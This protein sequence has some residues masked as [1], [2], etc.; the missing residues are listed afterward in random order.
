VVAD[1]VEM[2]DDGTHT[3]TWQAN[4]AFNEFPNTALKLTDS[5]LP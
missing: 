5:P 1:Q 3:F 4:Y 2:L